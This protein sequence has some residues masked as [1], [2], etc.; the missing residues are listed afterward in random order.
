LE[1]I[2]AGLL[3]YPS[4]GLGKSICHIFIGKIRNRYS[5][6][7]TQLPNNSGTSITN[8]FE[9]INEKV[10]AIIKNYQSSLRDDLMSSLN[11][12]KTYVRGVLKKFFGIGMSKIIPQIISRFNLIQQKINWIEQWPINTAFDKNKNEYSIVTV[13]QMGSPNWKGGYDVNDIYLKYEIKKE[14]LE[15][16]PH[17]FNDEKIKNLTLICPSL[18]TDKLKK[19]TNLI[20]VSFSYTHSIPAPIIFSRLCSCTKHL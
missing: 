4:S 3:V 12:P 18:S 14:I 7:C 17:E 9:M 11:D 13:D 1:H 10:K 5:V 20:D 6:V 19:T 16:I 15:S 8:G 2:Y